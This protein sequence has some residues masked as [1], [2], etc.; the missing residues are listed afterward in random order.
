MEEREQLIVISVLLFASFFRFS[1]QFKNESSDGDGQNTPLIYLRIAIQALQIDLQGGDGRKGERRS[2][3]RA[4]NAIQVAVVAPE[5]ACVHAVDMRLCLCMYAY[6]RDL[7]V[8]MSIHLFL[9]SLSVCLWLVAG[10][11][12]V[13]VC[14]LENEQ[15][16]STMW[17]G[18]KAKKNNGKAPASAVRGQLSVVGLLSVML[19]VRATETLTSCH[20]I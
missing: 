4:N 14:A 2:A 6:C 20:L 10:R 18:D 17:T 5:G 11:E 16:H 7:T 13:D 9:F 15:L 8:C 3:T 1:N 19:A 12:G